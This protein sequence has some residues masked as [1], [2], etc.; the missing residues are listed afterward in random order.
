M[1][2]KWLSARVTVFILLLGLSGTAAGQETRLCAGYITSS[3]N[4]SFDDDDHLRW[5]NR[6]W[7]GRCTGLFFCVSG[8]PNWNT[9]VEKLMRKHRLTRHPS[10][11]RRL[12]V[13]GHRMGFEWA[14]DNSIRKIHTVD[15]EIWIPELDDAADLEPVLLTLEQRVAA[16]LDQ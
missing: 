1:R 2:M 9:G 15:L 7:T 13:L 11:L 10:L 14:K 8:T 4:L 6:F 3:T 5:Y 12:C 16:R